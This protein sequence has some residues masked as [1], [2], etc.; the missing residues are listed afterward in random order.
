MFGLITL[1]LFDVE[2]FDEHVIL[3]YIV[4]QKHHNASTHQCRQTELLHWMRIYIGTRF[5]GHGFIASEWVSIRSFKANAFRP[6]YQLCNSFENDEQWLLKNKPQQK[7]SSPVIF[8]WSLEY[9]SF[10]FLSPSEDDESIFIHFRVGWWTNHKICLYALLNYLSHWI[11]HAQ[12]YAPN[13]LLGKNLNWLL[14][15]QQILIWQSK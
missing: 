2:A 13:V 4:S 6:C 12:S 8:L 5:R 7:N 3:S 1:A 15:A 10:P 11:F 9:L 14:Q